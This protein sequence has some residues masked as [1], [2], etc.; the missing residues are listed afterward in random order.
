MYNHQD[1]WEVFS[2]NNNYFLLFATHSFSNSWYAK[3]GSP[4]HRAHGRHSFHPLLFWTIHAVGFQ[5]F[6]ILYACHYNPRLVYLL[7][8]FIRPFLC[9]Q[10]VCLRKFS[11]YVWLL[12]KSR[13]LWRAYSI[14][15]LGLGL[16]ELW[17]CF[18]LLFV[19]KKEFSYEKEKVGTYEKKM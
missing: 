9:F 2:N 8:H 13:L 17:S 11:P 5:K 10:G 3:L 15:G 18:Y 4:H 7:P 16:H 6:H 1:Q 14:L 19:K 12:F